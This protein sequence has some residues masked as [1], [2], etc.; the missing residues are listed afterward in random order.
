MNMDKELE[1]VHW[2]HSAGREFQEAFYILIAKFDPINEH[3]REQVGRPS[4][5]VPLSL[6]TIL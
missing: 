3:W 1:E 5:K 4:C 2:H 6:H